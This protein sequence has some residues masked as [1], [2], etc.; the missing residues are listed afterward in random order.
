[1]TIFDKFSSP[2]QL[3]VEF[4]DGQLGSLFSA[5]VANRAPN[6]RSAKRLRNVALFTFLGRLGPKIGRFPG[7][8]CGALRT[9]PRKQRCAV[10]L[11]G[12]AVKWGRKENL[13]RFV[14]LPSTVPIPVRDGGQSIDANAVRSWCVIKSHIDERSPAIL[15]SPEHV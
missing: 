12:C 7:I 14:N 5:E 4:A 1:M 15:M 10:A 2:T 13:Y 11:V 8:N 9:T 3:A 6:G